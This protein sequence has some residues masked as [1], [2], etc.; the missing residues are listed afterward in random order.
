MSA[1]KVSRLVLFVTFLIWVIYGFLNGFGQWP[2]AVAFGLA[3]GLCLVTVVVISR[4]VTVKLMD[5]TMVGYFVVA[6]CVTFIARLVSFPYYSPVVIW[7]MYAAVAWGSV[8]AGRPFTLQYARESAPPEHWQSTA[9]WRTNLIISMVWGLAFLIN[10][11][12]VVIALNSKHSS[13]LLAVIFPLLTLAA[14][15]IF[16]MCY[17]GMGRAGREA[18]PRIKSILAER[19]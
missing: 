2:L 13:L 9:F 4:K 12:L 17:S 11:A 6:A 1:Q 14:A 10:I 18:T 7:L 3:S 19:R 15:W 8:A 16:T 5:L